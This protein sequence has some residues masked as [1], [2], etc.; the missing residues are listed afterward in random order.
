MKAKVPD[1]GYNLFRL[2]V[3]CEHFVQ[4]IITTKEN[5]LILSQNY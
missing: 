1:A 4:N 3:H 5:H 2:K